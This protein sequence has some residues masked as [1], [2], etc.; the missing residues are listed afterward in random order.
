MY[1]KKTKK[2]CPHNEGV[3]CDEDDV[4]ECCGWNPAGRTQKRERKKRTY[5]RHPAP[6]IKKTVIKDDR[7]IAINNTSGCTGVYW[8]GRRGKWSAEIR[9]GKKGVTLD[10]LKIWRMPSGP[11]K[12]QKSGY[13]R[14]IINR[15]LHHGHG[16]PCPGWSL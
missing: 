15:R 10:L 9:R 14:R 12:K 4:C 2:Q 6:K 16:I 13:W 3:E 1:V 7:E 5:T 8:N 11:E